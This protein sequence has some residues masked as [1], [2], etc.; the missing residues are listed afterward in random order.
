MAKQQTQKDLLTE[1]LLEVREIKVNQTH[2]GEDLDT[3]RK[4]FEKMDH[5]IRGNGEAGLSE[6]I[7]NLEGMQ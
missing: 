4:K 6:R 5:A 3:L 7:R 1:V 2:F